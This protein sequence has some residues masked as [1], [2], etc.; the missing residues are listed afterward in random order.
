[1]NGNKPVQLSYHCCFGSFICPAVH[2]SD[3]MQSYLQLFVYST[4]AVKF[5]CWLKSRILEMPDMQTVPLHLAFLHR[6]ITNTY[7]QS[8]AL[9]HP[10]QASIICHCAIWAVRMNDQH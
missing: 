3:L 4:E 1:M 5:S 2:G 9:Y 10:Q 7:G 6:E 8:V